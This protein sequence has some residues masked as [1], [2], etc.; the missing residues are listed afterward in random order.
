MPKERE[1]RSILN[2]RVSIHD[3]VQEMYEERLTKDKMSNVFD[4][5][6]A[7]EKIR[8]NFCLDGVSCQLCTGGPCRISEKAGATLGSCGID[9]DAMA[10]RDMLL[11]NVMGTSTYTHHAYNAFRT[12]KSTAEGKTPFQ[13]TDEPKLRD[14]AERVGLDTRGSKE[15]IA[16]R[17]ADFLID[18]LSSDY[19]EP[20]LMVEIFAPRYRKEKWKELALYPAGVLHEIKDST[21]SCLTNVDGY[22]VSMAKKALRTGIATIYGAQL[23]LEMVQDILF[24]TPM[25]HEIDTDLGILEPEYVNIAF[26]GHEPWTGAATIYAAR[27]PEIQQ[28]AREAGAKGLKVIGSI[29]TGQELAQRFGMEDG[30][31]RGLLGNW[32]FIEP[33]LATG[34]LD[35]FAMDENC[36]PP[37]LKPYEEKYQVTLVSVNDLVRIPGVEKNYDYKPTEVGNVAQELINLAIDNFKKRHQRG[38]KAH[39]PGKVQKAIAGF[40]PGAILN[41][42]NGRLEPLIDLIREG[43]IKGIVALINCT[44]LANGPHDYMTVNL[45]RELIKRDILVITGGCGCHGLEVA[46]LASLEAIEL[47]GEGLKDVC[48]KLQIPPVLPF[49][50]CTDTGR[51]QMIVTALADLLDVDTTELPVAVTAPQ[52]LEQKA[53]IDG[54]FSLAY[55]LYTHLSPTPPITGGKELVQLLTRDLEEISGGRVA[56]GDDPEKVADEMET[57][58]MNKRKALG[59]IRE[60]SYV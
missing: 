38:I 7:Q 57:H 45:T 10:M 26:N 31:F 58:I 12:L 55:G 15:D 1:Y 52:Y 6:D 11:R 20:P 24:G 49:G 5:F 4:R 48:Q 22:H 8:C 30:V 17:F 60:P 56:L 54:I 13:I 46:G 37:Y 36:S 9:P 59:F 34:A 39:V 25:P 35:V 47:A 28:K 14:M 50:T 40:S 27:N 19:D 42:L 53:T 3:S 43:S 41:L 18:Q 21:A 16:I 23:G 29:E 51:M 32:L 33:A 44:T 2:G